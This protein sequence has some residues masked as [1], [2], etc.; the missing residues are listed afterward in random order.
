MTMQTPAIRSGILKSFDSGV[1]VA[2]VQFF[3]SLQTFVS[4]IP[5]SRDIASGDL[6][7]GRR[8]AVAFFDATNQSDAVLFA[9]WA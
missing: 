4:A 2:T 5:V 7:A 3:S 6:T 9:V 8:V 1:Y